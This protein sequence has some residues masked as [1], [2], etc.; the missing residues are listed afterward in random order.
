MNW[1]AI[2]AIGEI[3]G[4]TAVV[5][6]LIY[7]ALQLRANSQE[8][9]IASQH[10]ITEAFRNSISSVQD[11]QRADLIVKAM[12]GLEELSDSERLQLVSIA[13]SLLR[14]WEEAHYQFSEGRLEESMWNAMLAQFIDIMS[15]ETWQSIWSIRKHTYRKEFVA[16]VDSLDFG[17]YKLK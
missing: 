7:V 1:D 6:S 8:T 10:E 4:A 5:I 9:R 3:V 13:Q 17:D 15:L 14:V 2:G 16:F 12:D 11:P